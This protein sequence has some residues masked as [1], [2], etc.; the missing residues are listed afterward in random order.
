MSPV[1]HFRE[2][3]AG[4]GDFWFH[5]ELWAGGACCSLPWWFLQQCFFKAP[6]T[7]RVDVFIKVLVI[8]RKLRATT[9]CKHVILALD[10]G[11]NLLLL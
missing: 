7:G 3:P 8:S 1:G 6:G 5:G 11:E 4:S 2:P 10:L 9:D